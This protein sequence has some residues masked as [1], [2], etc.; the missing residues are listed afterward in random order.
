MANEL[1]ALLKAGDQEA[2]SQLYHIYA[3]GIAGKILRLVKSKAIAE[4]LL[5]D[6]FLKVW[7]NRQTID[8]DKSFRSYLFRIAENLVV[9]LFRRAAYNQKLLNYL[10]VNTSELYDPIADQ[11][12]SQEIK[13]R[14]LKALDTLP[15]QRKKIYVLCKLEGKSYQ[16]VSEL[17]GISLSTIN[18]HIVKATKALKSYASGQELT[19]VLLITAYL[20]K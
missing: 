17:L 20:V 11:E 12:L 10:A 16:E 3:P 6:V 5:Q 13:T 19:A 4:E 8:L 9:D 7:E 2:F 15:P 14:L 18:D 1:V